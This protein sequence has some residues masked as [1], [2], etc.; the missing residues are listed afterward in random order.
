MKITKSI[1]IPL[2]NGHS[3]YAFFIYHQ[4]LNGNPNHLHDIYYPQMKNSN[5]GVTIFQ[6]SGD[7]DILEFQHN[8]RDPLVALKTINCLLLQ[9]RQH[10]KEFHLITDYKTLELCKKPEH[11][12]FILSFEGSTV[13]AQDLS[14]PSTS[15]YLKDSLFDVGHKSA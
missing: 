9:I 12:G 10:S 7:F 15:I 2:F 1:H 6:V 13:L 4:L 3:D 8:P 14:L 5:I 11:T